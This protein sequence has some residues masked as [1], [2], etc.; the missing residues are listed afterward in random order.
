MPQDDQPLA[1]SLLAYASDMGLVGTSILPHFDAVLRKD[2]EAGDWALVCQ[3][4]LEAAVYLEALTLN[5]WPRYE[6]YGGPVLTIGADPE[7]KGNP[8]TGKANKALHDEYGYPYVAIPETGHMLQIEKPQACI[9]AME[10]YLKDN[11]IVD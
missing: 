5:L 3:R 7:M 11:G 10:A 4:E 9:E 8:P 1:R 6:E 2:E